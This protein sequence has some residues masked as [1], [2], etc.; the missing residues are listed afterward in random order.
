MDKSR[1]MVRRGRGRRR[2]RLKSRKRVDRFME[3]RGN[4]CKT[5]RIRIG[6]RVRRSFM[7][8]SMM[9]E[10]ILISKKNEGGVFALTRSWG[11]IIEDT[12]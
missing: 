6:N 5:P 4:L 1:K 3:L 9:K 8:M 11:A 12:W 10:L 7:R 2:T